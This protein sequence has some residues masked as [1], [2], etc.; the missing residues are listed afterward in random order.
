MRCRPSLRRSFNVPRKMLQ[1]DSQKFPQL[2]L[3]NI[4]KRKYDVLKMQTKLNKMQTTFEEIQC[5]KENVLQIDN[6]PSYGTESESENPL[7][8]RI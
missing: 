2:F 1:I 4:W 7:E 8:L 3:E 5:R 6:L